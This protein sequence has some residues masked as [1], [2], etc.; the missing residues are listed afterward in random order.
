MPTLAASVTPNQFTVI[1]DKSAANIRRGP[2]LAYNATGGLLKGASTT[3]FGRNPD[4]TWIYVAIP[5]QP[6][7]F[8]WVT[9]LPQ[10]VTVS[11]NVMDLPLMTYGQPVPAFLQNCT[12]HTLL[13]TPGNI[14]IPDRS[15]TNNKVQ[16]NPNTYFVF[17]E[18]VKDSNDNIVQIRTVTLVEGQTIDIT[19][20]GKGK[21]NSCP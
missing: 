11:V 21:V 6:G 13:V 10:Y 20:D 17:D 19:K 4:G 14:S 2:G 3:V 7:T 15:N 16:L 12:E 9:A 18:N 5:G 1:A 8:G